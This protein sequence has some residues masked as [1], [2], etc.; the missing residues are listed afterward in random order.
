MN[1]SKICLDKNILTCV[2]E[3][4]RERGKKRRGDIFFEVFTKKW[5][6]TQKKRRGERN[7]FPN[8][9]F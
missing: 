5:Y 4:K 8:F 7:S 2:S 6:E 1:F 9:F 3:R